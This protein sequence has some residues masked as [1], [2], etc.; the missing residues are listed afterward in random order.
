MFT[1]RLRMPLLVQIAAKDGT[2]PPG[3]AHKAAS[4]AHVV[5]CIEYDIDHFDIYVG[6][7]FERAV[8]DEVDFLSE[9]LARRNAKSGK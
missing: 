5:R 3:P 2:V 8:K 4:R 1:W 6:K 7:H 9:F